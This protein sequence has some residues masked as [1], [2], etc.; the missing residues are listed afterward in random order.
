MKLYVGD[1]L[2]CH[3]ENNGWF[4][5]GK[6]YEIINIYH[7]YRINVECLVVIN[8]LNNKC[9]LS[10]NLYK[11]LSYKDWFYHIKDERKDKLKKLNEISKEE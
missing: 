11:R 1:I 6:R 3:N 10:I 8:D 2:I 5:I 7:D 4:T 9:N